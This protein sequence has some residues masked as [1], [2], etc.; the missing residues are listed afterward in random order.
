MRKTRKRSLRRLELVSS[1]LRKKDNEYSTYGYVLA[2]DVVEALGAS[3][4]VVA[5]LGQ[6]KSYELI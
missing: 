2:Y 4:A 6:T 1:R 3:S 5:K